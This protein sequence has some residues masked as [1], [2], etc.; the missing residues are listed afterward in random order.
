[1][2]LSVEQR[3]SLPVRDGDEGRCPSS[4]DPVHSA[5]CGQGRLG[6][7]VFHTQ[8]GPRVLPS[9]FLGPGLGH[10]GGR[11]LGVH[12]EPAGHADPQELIL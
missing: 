1:M 11:L 9:G 6:W 4:R 10:E 7:L 2:V 12:T 8:Q 3:G 5:R